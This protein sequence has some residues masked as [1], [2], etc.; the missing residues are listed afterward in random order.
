MTGPLKSELATAP[1]GVYEL[2]LA[3]VLS[4]SHSELPPV[5]V[6]ASCGS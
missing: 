3:S 6:L 4:G 1:Q 2:P 5:T